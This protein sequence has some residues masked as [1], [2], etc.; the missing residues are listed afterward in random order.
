MNNSNEVRQLILELLSHRPAFRRGQP[1]AAPMFEYEL[2]V[3]ITKA[4]FG[5]DRP[6]QRPAFAN[7]EMQTDRTDRLVFVGQLTGLLERRHVRH[8]RGA[9]YPPVL[10]AANNTGVDLGAQTEIVG[11][12]DNLCHGW[13]HSVS[14][15]A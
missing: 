7:I 14:P 2:A 11:V 15:L 6:T 8:D 4:T 10:E 1:H 5:K 9:R 13:G 3:G 12:Y